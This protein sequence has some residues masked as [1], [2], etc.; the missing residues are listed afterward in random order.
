MIILWHHCLDTPILSNAT[1]VCWCAFM[2][3][4]GW[5]I[6]NELIHYNIHIGWYDDVKSSYCGEEY[7]G[8]HDD[9]LR[10]GM[11]ALASK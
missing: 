10:L 7:F 1:V 3:V 4:P 9:S 5:C 6:Y 11:D 2:S 8:M